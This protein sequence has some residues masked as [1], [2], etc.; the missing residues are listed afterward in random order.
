MHAQQQR[1]IDSSRHAP[2]AA[3]YISAAV[4]HVINVASW[5]FTENGEL[6]SSNG[7]H[8]HSR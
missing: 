8:W 3:A 2:A 7:Q 4:K 1:L 6:G 5:T